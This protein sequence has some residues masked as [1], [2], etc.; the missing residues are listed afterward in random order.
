SRYARVGLVVPARI[1]KDRTRGFTCV[2]AR[3]GDRPA[4]YRRE[5]RN[6]KGYRWKTDRGMDKQLVSTRCRAT[7]C[8]ASRTVAL[9]SHRERFE[10]TN[11]LRC[12]GVSAANAG[13]LERVTDSLREGDH[14]RSQFRVGKLPARLDAALPGRTR[15]RDRPQRKKPAAEPARPEYILALRAV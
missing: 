10:S 2:R 6:C 11:G 1:P 9:R 14:T 5:N 8:S 3:I 13:S 7:S 15:G 12:P 4:L